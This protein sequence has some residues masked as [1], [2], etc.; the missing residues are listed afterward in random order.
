M[1]F[2]KNN[3]TT[4]LLKS[5]DLAT[6][7]IWNFLKTVDSY[8]RKIFLDIFHSFCVFLKRRFRDWP[9][10][11]SSGQIPTSL[12]PIDRTKFCLWTSEAVQIKVYKFSGFNLR[13][14]QIPSPETSFLNIHKDNGKCLRS[15]PIVIWQD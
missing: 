15:F 13:T 7:L 6:Y 9:L 11:L 14:G 12:G 10:S 2:G 5:A 8:N 3:S 4:H 1:Y